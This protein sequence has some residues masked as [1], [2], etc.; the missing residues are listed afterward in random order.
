MTGAA[1]ALAAAAALGAL[2]G[3][4]ALRVPRPYGGAPVVRA[5]EIEGA[6]RVSADAVRGRLGTVATGSW[7]WSARR[8]FD[9]VVW[10]NDLARIPRIYEA[11]GFFG[12]RVVSHEV[13]ERDG[14]VVPA[15]VVEEGEPTRLVELEVRGLDG[16]PERVARAAER[17]VS[18]RVGSRFR[19]AD[20]TG[21]KERIVDVLRSEGYAAAEVEGE[22]RVDPEARR[23]RAVLEI[24]PGRRYRFADPTLV[25]P[26]PVGIPPEAVLAEARAIVHEAEWSSPAILK[27][28]EARLFRIGAFSAVEVTAGEPDPASGTVPVS[29]AV[30]R[31]ASRTI[32]AGAGIGL[33]PRR[34]EVHLV[35]RWIERPSEDGLRTIRL[36]ALAGWAL[37][38]PV[39]TSLSATG[40]WP[41]RDAPVATLGLDVDFPWLLEIPGLHL[42][43]SAEG[44]L[45]VVEAYRL[46]ALRASGGIGWDPSPRLQLRALYELSAA[47]LLETPL[48]A[49]PSNPATFGCAA[50]CTVSAVEL[51]AAWETHRLSDPSLGGERVRLR[52]RAAG[53]PLGG[54]YDLVGVI[55]EASADRPLSERWS[56]RARVGGGGVA[57]TG[58]RPLPAFE[59]L[60]GGG[61]AMR[62]YG[63]GRL[64]PRMPA[65]LGGELHAVPV[66]GR[67]LLEGT[68]EVRRALTGRLTAVAFVDAGAATVERFDAGRLASALTFA[69]GGG[70][71]VRT[72]LGPLRVDLAYRP[73]IGPALPVVEPPGA[74]VPLPRGASCFGL[75]GGGSRAG[76]PD[77]PCA[78]HISWGASP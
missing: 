1:R 50:P 47:R 37:A 14:G 12:A 43:A 78:I 11:E 63:E 69:V 42:F 49:D 2:A 71:R 68:L 22:A 20:W 60:A 67:G 3:C 39:T 34:D 64:S 32:A 18:L 76:A 15:V 33:S 54:G 38:P 48:V 51:R 36:R 16:L 53:G 66:G 58:D 26:V 9:P 7:P 28:A 52:V 29:V 55:A 70:L 24:D 30:R 44:E 73:P 72:P 21:S 77:S 75:G 10:A 17:A 41:P 46:A 25:T 23:A 13:R 45:D 61:Y 59:R 19:E 31:G 57:S 4:G 40:S 35:A 27:E 56:V 6:S 62:G 8:Y 5:V 74:D 65:R